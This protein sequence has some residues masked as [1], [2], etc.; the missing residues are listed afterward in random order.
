MDVN[1]VTVDPMS[2]L[3]IA[4]SLCQSY[5]LSSLIE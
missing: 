4:S 3:Y 2:I 1:T 5:A